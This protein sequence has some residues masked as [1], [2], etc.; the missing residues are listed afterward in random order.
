MGFGYSE[1]HFFVYQ[2]IAPNMEY[3]TEYGISHRIWNI[4]SDREAVEPLISNRFPDM[5]LLIKKYL[6]L[7]RR[8]L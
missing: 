2:N 8:S 7:F 6:N 4:A 1:A 5:V 3:R